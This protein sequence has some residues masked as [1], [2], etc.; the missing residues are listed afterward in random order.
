MTADFGRAPNH[1]D[2]MSSERTEQPKPTGTGT[3]TVPE[4][5]KLLGVSQRHIGRLRASRLLPGE[6]R[7]G[8]RVL[9]S[10]RQIDEWLN[11]GK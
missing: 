5:A 10:K 11:G 7:L 8:N 3:Y 1:G 9:F 4:L 2:P 6:M